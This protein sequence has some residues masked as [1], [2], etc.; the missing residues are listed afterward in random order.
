MIL[1]VNNKKFSCDKKKLNI[2]D[3]VEKYVLHCLVSEAESDE[4]E[5]SKQEK[6]SKKSR[7]PNLAGFCR[8]YGLTKSYIEE[9]KKTKPLQYES[10][11]MIFEDEALN[12][13]LS[14]TVLTAYLKRHLGYAEKVKSERSLCEDEKT[15]LVFDHDIE[16]AGK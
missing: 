2:T 12:S 9:L 10:L 1:C 16:D 11:C 13:E 7:F 8:Y 4:S 15:V 5:K 3:L 14:A 6:K